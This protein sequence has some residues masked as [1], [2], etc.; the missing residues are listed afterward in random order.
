MNNEQN[1]TKEFNKDKGCTKKCL[2]VLI[3]I[4]IAFIALYIFKESIDV[5][6]FGGKI[7]HFWEEFLGGAIAI[8][9]AIWA[10]IKY[11]ISCD[12]LFLIVGLAFLANGFI[13]V[14]HAFVAVGAIGIPYSSSAIFIPGTWTAGRIMLGAIFCMI[15]FVDCRE[16]DS[17]EVE[18]ELLQWGALVGIIAVIITAMFVFFELPSV[19]MPN[20]PFFTR[21]WEML[22]LI[23]LAIA[24]PKFYKI[25]KSEGGGF[26]SLLVVSILIGIFTQ[27]F[28]TGSGPILTEIVGGVEKQVF[29]PLFIMS[30]LIKVISYFVVFIGMF[31]VAKKITTKQSDIQS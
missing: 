2:G 9:V 15:Y 17:E 24:F 11:K 6:M 29:D 1:P 31:F 26:K 21:P 30:H 3:G 13:D 12:K 8:I 18:E 28:M 4:S 25:A 7:P 5:T 10:F 27:L 22:P 19:I 23:L 20:V 16:S 14:F